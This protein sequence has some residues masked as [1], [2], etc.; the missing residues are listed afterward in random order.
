MALVHDHVV[1]RERGLELA[2]VHEDFI[3]PQP[4]QTWVEGVLKVGQTTS[5]MRC[6]ILRIHRQIQRH[7]TVHYSPW[8]REHEYSVMGGNRLW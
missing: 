7:A 2:A 4:E 1:F 8:D 6:R 5:R 3:L